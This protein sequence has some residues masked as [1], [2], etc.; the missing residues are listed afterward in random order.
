M[1]DIGLNLSHAQFAPDLDAVME[2]ARAAGV[3]G[4][5]LTGTSQ[6]HSEEA[7]ALANR[8][9]DRARSTAG[10]HPHDARHWTPSVA[11]RIRELAQ[12]PRVL[13]VGECGID[14][15]RNFSTHDEQTRAF[16]AQMDLSLEL[17]KPAFLHWRPGS[18]AQPAIDAFEAIAR[19]FA[20]AGGRGV[21]HCFTG[22][23]AMLESSLEMGFSIGVTGW[24]CDERRGAELQALIPFIPAD[25][26]LIETDAPYLIPR[27]MPGAKK[28]RR[29]EPAF[30]IHVAQ[31][32][33]R[34]RGV[35]VEEIARVSTEN[36][37]ALFSWPAADL[38]AERAAH[39]AENVSSRA[40][41]SGGAR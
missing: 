2:R 22:T 21:V 20:A 17:G 5:L 9:P 39:S 19:P 12:D 11:R 29:N 40:P 33:A 32:V 41:S 26:L 27:T 3:E 35:S 25:R 10:V 16:A 37:R 31:E 36:A 4:F 1:I 8:F 18:D 28:L 24:V 30:L 13:C 34:L 38:S 6:K 15:D 14:Y 7:L 23:R